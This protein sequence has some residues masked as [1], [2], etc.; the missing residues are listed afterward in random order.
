[1]A[2]PAERLVADAQAT[3]G[4]VLAQE[5]QI[6]RRELVIVGRIGRDAAAHQHEVGLELGH[7][8]ELALGA[9]EIALQ[10]VARPGLEIAERLE[11]HDAQ[12]AI[13]GDAL[14]VG[15]RAFEIE[16]VI[17]EDLHAVESGRRDRGQLVDQRPAQ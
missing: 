8:V 2:A 17:L 7:E 15:G 14:H 13:L 3:P 11:Q 6:G 10:L 16:Q 12:P 4:R 1:M 9:V 5:A